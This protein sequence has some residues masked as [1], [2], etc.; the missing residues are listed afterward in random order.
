M[1]EKV[2]KFYTDS[3][4]IFLRISESMEEKGKRNV[5]V[6]NLLEE[7]TNGINLVAVSLF[8]FFFSLEHYKSETYINKILQSPGTYILLPGR[9]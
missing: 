3:S 1:N 6:E 5:K 7:E 4:E 9:L 2:R 8:L